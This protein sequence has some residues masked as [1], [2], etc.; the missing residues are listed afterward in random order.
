[1]ADK[2]VVVGVDGNK[3]TIEYSGNH[4]TLPEVKHKTHSGHTI[5]KKIGTA[6]IISEGEKDTLKITT[7]DKPPKS[8][9]LQIFNENH[10]SDRLHDVIRRYLPTKGDTKYTFLCKRID[11]LQEYIL[12]IDLTDLNISIEKE[13]PKYNTLT[14]NYDSEPTSEKQPKKLLKITINDNIEDKI[15][16][17][18]EVLDVILLLGS[19]YSETTSEL[20]TIKEIFSICNP[21]SIDETSKLKVINEAVDKLYSAKK[22]EITPLIVG[23]RKLL[24]DIKDII[25]LE[26]QIKDATRPRYIDIDKLSKLADIIFPLRPPKRSIP[27]GKFETVYLGGGSNQNIKRLKLPKNI[28]KI[29][30]LNTKIYITNELIIVLDKLSAA[31]KEYNYD[32]QSNYKS[33]FNSTSAQTVI[34][35]YEQ[36][37]IKDNK[38]YF[39]EFFGYG[40]LIKHDEKTREEKKKIDAN[41]KAITEIKGVFYFLEDEFSLGVEQLQYVNLYKNNYYY[42]IT[43]YIDGKTLR[44]YLNSEDKLLD[45]K[46]KIQIFK[47]LCNAVELLHKEN[48]V[49]G[50][51]KPENIMLVNTNKDTY[52]IKIIDLECSSQPAVKSEHICFLIHTPCYSSPERVLWIANYGYYGSPDEYIN[53]LKRNDIWALGLILIELLA[54]KRLIQILN[55]PSEK[56]ELEIQKYYYNAYMPSTNFLDYIVLKPPPDNKIINYFFGESALII[57]DGK[58]V[59]N[60]ESYS[61]YEYKSNL[62]SL[63]KD[64]LTYGDKPTGKDG[65]YPTPPKVSNIKELIKQFNIAIGEEQ[66]DAPAAVVNNG[67]GG[68]KK[69]KRKTKRKIKRKTQ[70]R[71]RKRKTRLINKML[72]KC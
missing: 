12:S 22:E 25:H 43:E 42:V 64:I 68:R 7:T 54:Q 52:S 35:I 4:F 65:Q 16:Q 34:D 11:K 71:K 53:N 51:L 63:I 31:I 2:P 72:N 17:I 33:Y 18:E 10:Y 38:L 30:E 29:Q 28:E 23:K 6:K 59:V 46:D 32:I 60:S 61:K 55:N 20:N 41:T 50:D 36:D 14:S 26:K 5:L 40:Q 69:K 58:A 24:N 39:P 57:D 9:I 3:I 8:Y 21:G 66:S 48:L 67:G 19:N 13:L 27:R 45:I 37:I 15:K 70:K 56:E 47:E 49:H 44:E 62:D 1:M